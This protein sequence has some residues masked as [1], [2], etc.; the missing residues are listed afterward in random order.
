[1]NTKPKCLRCEIK[2]AYTKGKF[3]SAWCADCHLEKFG[4]THEQKKNGTVIN[5]LPIRIN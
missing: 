5:K 1:M 3:S 4:C 2:D